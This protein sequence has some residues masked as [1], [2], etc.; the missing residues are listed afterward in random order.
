MR[1]STL[2]YLFCHWKLKSS[3]TKGAK[4][5]WTRY[6][7]EED[8]QRAKILKRIRDSLEYLSAVGKTFDLH[9]GLQSRAIANINKRLSKTD[10]IQSFEFLFLLL[11]WLLDAGILEMI[12][13]LRVEAKHL[14]F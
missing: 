8:T 3:G 12:D 7:A 11:L 2:E 1:L 6:W 13:W 5:S 14:A 9:F 10:I 4:K